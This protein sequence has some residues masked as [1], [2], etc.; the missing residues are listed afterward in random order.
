M[1]LP[2][3][4]ILK[5]TKSLVATANLKYQSPSQEQGQRQNVN[6]VVNNSSPDLT[7]EVK[8]CYPGVEAEQ[9]QRDVPD[10]ENPYKGLPE[11]R[12]LASAES[13]KKEMEKTIGEKDNIIK[14]LSIM[15]DM[16]RNNPLIV[17]KYVIASLD[18]LSEL[19]RLLT[20]SET[21]D[22]QL[23]DIE[24]TCFSAKYQTVKRIYITSGGEIYSIEM[25]PACLQLLD[26]FKISVNFVLI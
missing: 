25:S 1:T 10:E 22:I 9:E 23:S 16:Y 7:K 20:N 14:A 17:N 12:D 21:V 13:F 4:K 19:I 15:V 18:T 5:A 24:C 3:S 8:A 26:N 11:V 6:I 2:N